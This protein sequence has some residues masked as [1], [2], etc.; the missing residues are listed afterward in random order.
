MR[1]VVVLLLAATAALGAADARA[2]TS[3]GRWI[4]GAATFAGG[5]WTIGTARIA[6]AQMIAVTIPAQAAAPGIASGLVTRSGDVVVGTIASVQA[7]TLT[8]RSIALG[9]VSVPLDQVRAIV[10]APTRGAALAGIAVVDGAELANGNLLAGKLDYINDEEVGIDVGKR[11]QRVK[12][13]RVALITF[14]GDAST[15]A[16][17]H[18]LRLVGGDL[19]GGTIE[20]W[21]AKG[22]TVTTAHGRVAL[23]PQQVAAAWNARAAVQPLTMLA[24]TATHTPYFDEPALLEIDRASA[25][26][27]LIIAGARCE[28][29]LRV[30]AR[31]ELTWKLDGSARALVAVLAADTQAARGGNAVVTVWRDDAQAQVIEC[32]AG[33]EPTTVTIPLEGAKTLKLSVDFAKPARP[34]DG[35]LIGWPTLVR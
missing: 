6:D 13:D 34:G 21:D 33:A 1:H 32:R 16:E 9:P 20:S 14:A 5:T 22:V 8:M 26:M 24:P 30:G 23:A 28:H 3:D 31:Q 18:R 11:V 29:G 17:G 25:T 4:D 7:G 10:L 2:L 15:P 12:R 19:L 27:P 35:A